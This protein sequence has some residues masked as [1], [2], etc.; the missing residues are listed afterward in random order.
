MTA[1]EAMLIIGGALVGFALRDVWQ[2]ARTHKPTPTPPPVAHQ[3]DD[4][5]HVTIVRDHK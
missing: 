1:S 5:R 3:W 4:I 2:V